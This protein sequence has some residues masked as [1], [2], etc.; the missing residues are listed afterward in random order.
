MN[1]SGDTASTLSPFVALGTF[2]KDC[3]HIITLGLR[4]QFKDYTI[5]EQNLIRNSPL[6]FFPT[7][8]YVSV[9]QGA[10]KLTFPSPYSYHFR[11]RRFLQWTLASYL[12]IPRLKTRCYARDTQAK[13]ILKDFSLPLRVLNLTNDRSPGIIV[14]DEKKLEIIL[15]SMPRLTL[16]QEIPEKVV[17][18]VSL[19]FI[20][21][22]LLGFKF[23]QTNV[24][25]PPSIVE[26][27]AGV[28][29]KAG[30]DYIAIMWI[31]T[32]RGWLFGGMD[33]PPKE[34]HLSD[35]RLVNLKTILCECIREIATESALKCL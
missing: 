2:L 9:F 3:P 34:F 30:L 24:T 6:V 10:G 19:I 7:S 35:N 27:S 28:V 15:K 23:G 1:N 25:V 14:K 20:F 31:L 21:Y 11:K 33:F 12:D 13:V 22:K 29:K 32:E 5:E 26:L 16:I 4:P 18:E 8:K 17:T